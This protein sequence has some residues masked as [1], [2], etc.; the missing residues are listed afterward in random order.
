MCHIVCNRNRLY[1]AVL[2][3]FFTADTTFVT[4][5]HRSLAFILRAAAYFYCLL[6]RD[7]L[8]QVM[9]TDSHTLTAGFTFFFIYMGDAIDDTDCIKV[10]C[11]Y[12][13]SVTETSMM[14][15]FF[16]RHPG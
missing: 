6:I 16:L 11:L 2:F 4:G 9:W 14:T 8:D 5:V 1:R 7:Q 13:G 10:T 12:A 15:F 3:A